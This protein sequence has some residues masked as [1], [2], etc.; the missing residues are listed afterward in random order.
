MLLISIDGDIEEKF[1]EE[2]KKKINYEYEKRNKD[3]LLIVD[4]KDADKLTLKEFAE[5]LKEIT[6]R[7]VRLG[8]KD[9]ML[10]FKIA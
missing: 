9:K 2:L 6:H 5:L 4:K 8:I 7:K 1:R 10:Y 3:L